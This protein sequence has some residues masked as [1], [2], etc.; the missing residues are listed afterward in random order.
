MLQAALQAQ[1]TVA[2]A[3][4]KGVQLDAWAYSSLLKGLV[5]GRLVEE[6][7]KLVQEMDAL[8]ISPNVVSTETYRK[9]HRS[10]SLSQ[11]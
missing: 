1:Q 8:N 7:S 6:A 2:E 10:G 4:A 11:A 9:C 3:K 5:R